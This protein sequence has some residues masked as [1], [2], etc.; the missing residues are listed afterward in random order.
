VSFL[1]ASRSALDDPAKAAALRDYILRFGTALQKIKTDPD[2]FVKAFYVAKYGLTLAAGKALL[3]QQGAST[4]IE[5]SG[6]LVPAQQDLADL[7]ASAGEIPEKIDAS[8][9]F[10]NRFADAVREAAAG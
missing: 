7:Y 2:P 4:F 1:I 6:D 9:E 10:D 3:A 8:K 5:L